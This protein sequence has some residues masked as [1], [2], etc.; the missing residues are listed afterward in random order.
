M[1]LKIIRTLLTV[2]AILLVVALVNSAVNG[3]TFWLLPAGGSVLVD[4]K[5]GGYLH[6]DWKNNVWVVTRTDIEPSESYL[7]NLSREHSVADCGAFRPTRF[8]PYP[9]GDVNP[10]CM[11]FEDV[12]KLEHADLPDPSSESMQAHQIEFSTRSGKRVKI[13]W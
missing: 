8:L 12:Y 6:T 9:V 2:A 11:G 10:P 3:H 13:T 4:G 7:V 1:L 5:P